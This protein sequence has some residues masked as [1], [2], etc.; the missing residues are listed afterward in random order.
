MVYPE[1]YRKRQLS[2]N[3]N[4]DSWSTYVIFYWKWV[5]DFHLWAVNIILHLRCFVVIDLKVGEFKPEY[6]GK[7]SFNLSAVDDQLKHADD[8]SGVG[9]IL[10]KS[11]NKII[12]EYALRDT[13]KPMGVAAYRLTETMPDN[14]KG[15]LPT[16][17]A[18]EEELA[19]E[20]IANKHE[21]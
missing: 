11:R 13:A 10:C 8:Q 7:M 1:N 6:V 12:V 2:E 14:L 3:L 21:D 19:K 5:L 17:E 18:L 4:G 15:N 16:V 9:I 20:R